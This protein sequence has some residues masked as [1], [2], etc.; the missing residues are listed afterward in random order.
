MLPDRALTHSAPRDR[1][2]CRRALAPRRRSDRKACPT[3]QIRQTRQ[4]RARQDWFSGSQGCPSLGGRSDPP[5]ESFRRETAQH[6]LPWPCPQPAAKTGTP[7]A[8]HS[9]KPR[10]HLHR[11]APEYDC[12]FARFRRCFLNRRN[13]KWL[14][15]KRE[16]YWKAAAPPSRA[17]EGWPCGN[18]PLNWP[19][20]ARPSNRRRKRR[21]KQPRGDR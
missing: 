7:A 16:Q 17:L 19:R 12:R 10:G 11:A 2:R 1:R 15:P 5:A 6:P 8:P 9:K 18:R 4:W 14:H 21:E 13:R 20:R 3:S